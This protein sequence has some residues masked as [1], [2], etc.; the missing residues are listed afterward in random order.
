MALVDAA[1]AARGAS[2]AMVS[3]AGSR[4]ARA[5]RSVQRATSREDAMGEMRTL[6]D[7]FV[8]IW[9]QEFP[10][11]DQFTPGPE[12]VELLADPAALIRKACALL[13]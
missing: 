8:R 11:A 9:D 6:L 4:S 13:T 3:N 7:E 1:L 12:V 2:N 5:N 10:P